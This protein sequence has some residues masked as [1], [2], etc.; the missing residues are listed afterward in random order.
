MEE[1]QHREHFGP[2]TAPISGVAKFQVVL[3]AL[4]A[5][6]ALHLAASAVVGSI[7]ADVHDIDKRITAL[8]VAKVAQDERIS[9]LK[10]VISEFKGDIKEVIDRQTKREQKENEGK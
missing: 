7:R 6:L 9:D 2:Q 1:G 4:G 3:S 8:E 5:A 10:F